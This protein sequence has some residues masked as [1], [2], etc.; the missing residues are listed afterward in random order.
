MPI[1]GM[2]YN[3]LG[4]VVTFSSNGTA[5][6]GTYQTPVGE[7]S[8]LYPLTGYVNT[9]TDPAVGWVV[10]WSND[11]GDSNSVTCW[12]GQYFSD[13]DPEVLITLWLLRT[14]GPEA[15]NWAATQ[16]GEDVFF[17]T[18]EQAASSG[19]LASLR[20]PAHPVIHPL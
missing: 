4:S 15:Q 11:S 18:A 20:A 3:E 9:D 5:L 8:G 19:G 13:G 12:A 14:E 2:W 6:T 1:D 16:V 17:R 7:A 10:L